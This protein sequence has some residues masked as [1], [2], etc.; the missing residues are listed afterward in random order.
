MYLTH[1]LNLR[2]EESKEQVQKQRL[3]LIWAVVS[4]PG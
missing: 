4:Q 2:A 1:L 3:L